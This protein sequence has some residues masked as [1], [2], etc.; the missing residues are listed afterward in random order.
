M[1][2][3]LRHALRGLRAHDSLLGRLGLGW[4]LLLVVV[5]LCAPLAGYPIGADVDLSQASQGMSSRHLLGTD[6]LGRD[7]FARLALA[8]RAFTGPGLLAGLVALTA[9]PTGALAGMHGGWVAHL[10]R[11]VAGVVAS[12]PRFV[13]VL[14]LLT[15][16]GNTPTVLGLAIGLA[17]VPELAEAVRARVEGLRVADFVLASRAHGVPEG[18]LLWLHLVLGATHQL[19]ARHLIRVFAFTVVVES[20]LADLGGFGVQEPQPSWGN[21]LVFEWGRGLGPQVIAPAAALLITLAACAAAAGFVGGRRH[22]G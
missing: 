15:I 20:T 21:L 19:V 22:A 18:R 6:H 14:L 9:V 13:L 12:V 16:Y 17:Y 4:L 10:T 1:T 2:R 11:Y 7:T 8:C 3:W 5:A